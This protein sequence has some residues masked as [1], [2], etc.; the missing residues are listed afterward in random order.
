MIAGFRFNETKGGLLLLFTID[1]NTETPQFAKISTGSGTDANVRSV[2]YFN[3]GYYN[4]YN[5]HVAD[6]AEGGNMVF[7]V[8]VDNEG[9][10]IGNIPIVT[11]SGEIT[12]QGSSRVSQKL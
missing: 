6:I 2:E 11:K 7:V 1:K 5:I 4:D 8:L 9:A 3:S 10:W 12:W